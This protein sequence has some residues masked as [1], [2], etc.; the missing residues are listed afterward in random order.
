MWSDLRPAGRGGSRGFTLIEMLLAIVIIGVGLAGVLMAFSVTARYSA[1]PL[2]AKQ[3]LAIAEGMMEEIELKPYAVANGAAST[4]TCSRADFD[5]VSDY[6]G[7]TDK[8]ICN[9]DGSSIASLAGY[10]VSVS[11]SDVTLDGVGAKKIVVSARFGSGSPLVL[12]GWRT[13]YAQ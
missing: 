2:V 1:D 12:V 13:G 11:V 8:P 3:L 10:T 9:I 7:Y 6:N 5:D 4:S